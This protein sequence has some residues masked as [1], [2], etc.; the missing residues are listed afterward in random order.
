MPTQPM[1]AR[2]SKV[3]SEQSR[4]YIE[5]EL[6]RYGANRFAY[7][8]EPER[9]VIMFELQGRR[10]R[11][12]LPLPD[13]NAREFTHTVANQYGTPRERTPEG[14][15]AAYEQ[16]IRSRWAALHLV[17]KAKLAAV[18]AG[19]STLE[20][21]FLANVVLPNGETVAERLRPELDQIARTGM[22][23]PLLPA[24]SEHRGKWIRE[25]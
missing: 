18:D 7:M 16:A 20:D 13:E 22:L 21:E 4:L 12:N 2:D 17:V 14:R 1:Y 23:P 5:R 25:E 10:Y 11:F 15:E 8:S 3:P 19:I 9:A 6:K 24:P